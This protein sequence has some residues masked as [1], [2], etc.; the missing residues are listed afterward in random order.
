MVDGEEKTQDVGLIT[1]RKSIRLKHYDYAEPGMYFVT[2]C[3]QNKK[4]LFGNIVDGAMRL[5]DCGEI[6]R[7]TWNDLPNHYRNV[8]L[9]MCMIMPNHFHGIIMLTDGVGPD[10][11]TNVGAA[12]TTK[13]GLSEIVR[14][15]KT[16]SSRR[17]NVLRCTPDAS[18][19][20]R[21]FYEC[22]I[23]NER[24]LFEIQEYIQNNPLKWDLDPENVYAQT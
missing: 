5:N 18:V 1:R 4:C 16:F 23:R 11:N 8:G 13:H 15:F 14:G 17:I 6:V 19:W 2:I 9:D 22:V 20:Q 10:P 12:P 3:T 24:E 21:N 7:Q